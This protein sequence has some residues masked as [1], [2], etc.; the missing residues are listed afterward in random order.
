MQHN[1]MADGAIAPDR[2]LNSGVG[3]KNGAVLHI[4]VFANDQI[5]VV[6]SKNCLKPDTTIG[7][8]LDSANYGCIIGNE[9]ACSAEFRATPIYFIKH[10]RILSDRNLYYQS[11]LPGY[12]AP[13]NTGQ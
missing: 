11:A 10:P 12:F 4:G 5:V 13:A 2:E 7:R 3:M 9:L 6:A 8:E 1:S